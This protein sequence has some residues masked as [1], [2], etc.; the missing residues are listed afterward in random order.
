MHSAASA[1]RGYSPHIYNRHDLYANCVG[2]AFQ[3]L[4]VAVGTPCQLMIARFADHLFPT[5]LMK[6]YK[7]IKVSERKNQLLK[8]DVGY[9]NN[10]A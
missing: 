3:H 4:Y 8:L 7:I 2:R 1:H 5:E 10:L 9:N 6:I